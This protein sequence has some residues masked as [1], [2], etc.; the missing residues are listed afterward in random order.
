MYVM[1]FVFF[2]QTE[3]SHQLQQL[4]EKAKSGGEFIQR[5]KGQTDKVNVSAHLININFQVSNYL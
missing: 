5:L 3:L 1:A 2:L 4:S